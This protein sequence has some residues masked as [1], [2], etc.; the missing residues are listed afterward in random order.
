MLFD[1]SGKDK[2]CFSL[3]RFNSGFLRKYPVFENANLKLDTNVH[4]LFSPRKSELQMFETVVDLGS[5]VLW[6]MASETSLLHMHG[7]SLS[8]ETFH[9]CCN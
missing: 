1:S 9:C 6:S 2:Y 3:F 5:V 7:T 4:M 8:A